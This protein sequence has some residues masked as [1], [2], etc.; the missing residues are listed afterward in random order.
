MNRPVVRCCMLCGPLHVAPWSRSVHA[1][2]CDPMFL[3]DITVASSRIVDGLGDVS[4]YMEGRLP[5]GVARIGVACLP[6]L[7]FHVRVDAW[8][9]CGRVDYS[10]GD[11]VG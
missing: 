6:V 2:E 3:R 5:E 11:Q 8:S 10:L 4:L 9:S 7:W 1:Q